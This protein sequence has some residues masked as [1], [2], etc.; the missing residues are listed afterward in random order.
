[1]EA[2]GLRSLNPKS[3]TEARA[4][5]NLTPFRS[6]NGKH[7]TVYMNRYLRLWIHFATVQLPHSFDREAKELNRCKL[8]ATGAA[9]ERRATAE[10]NAPGTWHRRQSALMASWDRSCPSFP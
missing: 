2:L 3:K 1:M 4:D 6:L 8:V 9:R 7:V 10:R 5:G